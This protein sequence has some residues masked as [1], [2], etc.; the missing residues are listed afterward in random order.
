MPQEVWGASLQHSIISSIAP[1]RDVISRSDSTKRKLKQSL[2]LSLPV[3]G[4]TSPS[5]SHPPSTQITAIV[6]KW[7]SRCLDKSLSPDKVCSRS[8]STVDLNVSSRNM[9]KHTRRRRRNFGNQIYCA[10]IQ[11]SSQQETVKWRS[12][13]RSRWC[14][15]VGGHQLRY[16]VI[17]WLIEEQEDEKERP[18]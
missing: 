1:I 3:G 11:E 9:K 14:G 8:N 5:P 12:K 4:A 2:L 13:M 15:L 18:T 10:S 7:S 6:Q 16:S 17:N